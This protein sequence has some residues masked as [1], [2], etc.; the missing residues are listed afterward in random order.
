MSK[1]HRY[2]FRNSLLIFMQ[3]PDTS[4]VAGYTSWQRNFKRQV[5]KGEHGIKIFAPAPYKATKKVERIDKTT[6]QR[7]IGKDG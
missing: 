5:R 6:N 7:I 2:S 3:K 4:M 1:L